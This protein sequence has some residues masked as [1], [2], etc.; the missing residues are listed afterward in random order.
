LLAQIKAKNLSVEEISS[1]AFA[2]VLFGGS[3]WASLPRMFNLLD[4]QVLD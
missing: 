2:S 1:L 3:C 4:A